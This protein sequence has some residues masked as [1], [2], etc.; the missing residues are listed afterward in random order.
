MNFK[1]H[2]P[3]RDVRC[4]HCTPNRMGNSAKAYAIGGGQG[5]DMQTR[6]ARAETSEE[7]RDIDKTISLLAMSCWPWDSPDDGV[8]PME[9]A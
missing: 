5:P 1:R 8:D 9:M 6:R 7:M 4:P 2:K 3:R